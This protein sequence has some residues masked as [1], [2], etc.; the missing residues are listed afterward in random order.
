MTPLSFHSSNLPLLALE[1]MRVLLLI[2]E[3]IRRLSSNFNNSMSSGYSTSMWYWI[4]VMHPFKESPIFFPTVFIKSTYSIFALFLNSVSGFFPYKENA[5]NRLEKF[6]ISRVASALFIIRAF[7]K[8]LLE[9]MNSRKSS[10]S[11]WKRR[12]RI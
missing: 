8:L 11:L 2:L 12:F 1:T 7:I 9:L 10:L 5:S 4:W 3:F 6:H